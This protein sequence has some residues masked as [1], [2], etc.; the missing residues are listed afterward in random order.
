MGAL[1]TSSRAFT[2][3][4]NGSGAAAGLV[5]SGRRNRP[6]ETRSGRTSH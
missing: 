6:V 1:T 5:F 3:T 4:A 2:H